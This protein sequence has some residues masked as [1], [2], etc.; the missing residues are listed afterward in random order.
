MALGS[1]VD[2]RIKAF[3]HPRYNT[4]DPAYEFDSL[5]ESQV[6]EEYRDVVL[7]ASEYIFD[8]YMDSN[9]LADLCHEMDK[10]IVA[11]RFEFTIE[12]EINGVPLLGKPDVYFINYAGIKCIYDFKVNGYYSASRTSPMKGYLKSYDIRTCDYKAHPDAG[13]FYFEECNKKWADQIAIYGWICGIE[14]GSMNH[15]AGIEQ[16]VGRHDELRI[17]Q[18]RLQIGHDYQM[19]LVDR[20]TTMWQTIVEDKVVDEESKELLQGQEEYQEELN[21]F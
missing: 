13:K 15:R 20:L 4:H 14:P 8:H 5:Y 6:D 1:A 10:S 7:G 16:F 2:A 17:C 18:H 19:Q 3:L 11:P 21:K 12:T 9:L